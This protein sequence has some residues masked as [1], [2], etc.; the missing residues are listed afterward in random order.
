M[1]KWRKEVAALS[2]AMSE[3]MSMLSL[4]HHVTLSKKLPTCVEPY[5]VGNLSR[6]THDEFVSLLRDFVDGVCFW[7]VRQTYLRN[8]KA[9]RNAFFHLMSLLCDKPKQLLIWR[10]DGSVVIVDG[11]RKKLQELQ[12]VETG[13]RKLIV[14]EMCDVW[15]KMFPKNCLGVAASK[16]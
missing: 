10:F 9:R 13:S 16:C 14:I 12:R 15:E 1:V 4:V 3:Y 11:L 7:E 2:F 8:M 5:I 6:I